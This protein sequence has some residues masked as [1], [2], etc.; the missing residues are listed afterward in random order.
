MGEKLFIGP[1]NKGL[2]TDREPFYIDNDS[3]PTLINAYQWRGRAKRKRGTLPFTRLQRYFDSTNYSY[4]GL[5]PPYLITLDAG[6]N[7]N[8]L[9][10]M[11]SNGSLSFT[12]QSTGSIIPGTASNP[13]TI[14][15]TVAS[16]TYTDNT[17]TGNLSPSGTINYATGAIVI[18]AAA[19]DTVSVVM[20][21]YPGLP[22]MGIRD[23]ILQ[24]QL[25][26]GTLDFDTTYSYNTLLVSPWTA[27][28]VS[29]YKNP[30]SATINSHSYT[31]KSTPTSFNWNG[32][33]YQQFWT[34]N[35]ENSLWATNGIAFTNAG[36]FASSN[37][38]M[39]FAPAS[40]ISYTSNT[41]TAIVVTITGSPLIKGD[42]VYF[43][44]WTGTNAATLNG[45][46]GFVSNVSGTSYTI[47]FP[48]GNVGAGAYTPGIIQYLTNSSSPTKDCIRWYDGDPTGGNITSFTGGLGW[49]NYMPPLSSAGFG[50][51]NLPELTTPYYLVGAR[52]IWPFKDR[53]LFFGIVVQSSTTGPF[54]L[55]DVILYSQ[56]GTPYYTASWDGTNSITSSTT[57]FEP[58]LVPGQ[59]FPTSSLQTTQVAAPNA[60]FSDV[61]GYGGFFQAGLAQP[62]TSVAPN[63]DVLIIGLSSKQAKLVYTGD[64]YV[65]FSLFIVN[66]ELGTSSGFSTIIMD[67]GVLS[68]GDR[69]ITITDQ[70]S[71]SRIDLEIPDQVF[72]ITLTANGAQ[73]ITAQRDFINEWV[74][75]T[76]P[77][78]EFVSTFPNQTLLY[79]YRDNSWG[80]FNENYT[81][82]GQFRRQSG[83]SW[84][85][86]GI[87]SW[88]AWTTPWIA[89]ESTAFQPDVA[90]G[91]QQG[92]I[93]IRDTETSE[94]PSLYVQ[95]VY[96]STTITGITNANPC[97]I[98]ANNNYALGQ[99]IF[100]EGVGGM[101]QINGG[102]YTITMVS[103]TTITL[104]IDS[105]L[106]GTYTSGGTITP[107]EIFSTNHGL[108]NDD[109]IT[110]SGVIGTIGT[111]LNG[112]IFAV[113][114][115]TTNYFFLDPP[116]PSGSY[117]YIGGG[118][119]TRMYIP[120][121][122][123]KQ[124]PTSWSLGRKTRIGPQMYLFTTET[125]T[126]Q[127]TLQLFMSTS[128]T[129][130]NLGFLVP[131][132]ESENNA[133]VY[134]SVLFTSPEQPFNS[135]FS[136]F[137]A[138]LGNGVTT[139]FTFVYPSIFDFNGQLVPGSVSIIVGSVAT[140][141]DTGTGTF[142]VTGTASSGTINYLTG[143][144]TINFSIA[145][146]TQLTTTSFQYTYPNIQ[147]PQGSQQVQTW[148][149]M[150]TSLIGD[151]VQFGFTLSDGQMKDPTFTNQFAE[152]EFHGAVIDIS[153][154]QIL[155]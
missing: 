70:I 120:Q 59:A 67:R 147:A 32:Q 3:F 73:R 64:A 72:E 146:T 139:S 149:R 115:A 69:G 97:V 29:F 2:K 61:T 102:V 121:I 113:S 144:I 18:A 105:T 48:Y 78:N 8:L 101:T 43:N 134:N 46:T 132:D 42:W 47:T 58:M 100:I 30:P 31:A 136:S 57:V 38:G 53:I 19:G 84:L 50:I 4:T 116:L 112:Q 13:I 152:I 117:T 96:L 107:Q 143:S 130:S 77:S 22:V 137:L 9:T 11:Y 104:G 44:E 12:L 94:A 91:N 125:T 7:G 110:F 10:G 28:N 155:A 51:A 17:G 99:Q 151:T 131:S 80:I 1:V 89:G 83:T 45:Q 150:N 135:N 141:I 34:I 41:A 128:Q 23:L 92:F 71:S 133:L 16:V 25:Y 154:S 14:I 140:F 75:F 62:I 66:S 37:V 114:N 109:Y 49:V 129:P 33:N 87:S 5:N 118:V 127:I 52:F 119:I 40:T 88:F 82:Y 95:N 24:A 123:S 56:N 27:Y 124:F 76:Y 111:F 138:N 148:H 93:L 98:T 106:Y 55:Q 79:N 65:P 20:S 85:S 21:Y 86:L 54:Y 81:A 103:S 74:Y 36:T 63:Q 145:P 68:L 15:D 90:A 6:G 126:A 108:N 153:P 60:Y 35:Y 26:P 142:N 122:Q 39:Q